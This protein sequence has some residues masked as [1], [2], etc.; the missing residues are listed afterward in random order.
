LFRDLDFDTDSY[1]QKFL[2]FSNRNPGSS[3]TPSVIQNPQST[4]GI[5]ATNP[6]TSAST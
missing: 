6:S 4:I 5:Y 3:E 1:P 2:G